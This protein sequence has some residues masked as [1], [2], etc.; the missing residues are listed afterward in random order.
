[1]AK[2]ATGIIR[3]ID[4]LGRIVIPKEIR[5]TLK[6]REGEPLEIFVDHNGEVVFKKYSPVGELSE[7]AESY[8][9]SLRKSTGHVTLISDLDEIV[10][11]AGSKS[12][13]RKDIGEAIENCMLMRKSILETNLFKREIAKGIEQA[14]SYTSA[15]IIT[16]QGDLVGAVTLFSEDKD[17]KLGAAERK[18]VEVAANFLATQMAN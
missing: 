4:E 15:P 2:K 11:S 3:R 7:F 17:M 18:L 9:E 13:L 12:H 5:R 14:A 10:A 1:M 6:M 16:D 8:A